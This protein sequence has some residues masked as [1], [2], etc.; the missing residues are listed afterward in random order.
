MENSTLI[1]LRSRVYP[2]H[3]GQTQAIIKF[4]STSQANL[5]SPVHNCRKFSA[6]LDESAL[7][8]YNHSCKTST[9]GENLLWGNVT[10]QLHFHP[11]RGSLT[12]VDVKENNRSLG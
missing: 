7:N 11:P 5:Y 2:V 9:C 6:V 10:E 1:S 3:I 12:N 4:I 8:K